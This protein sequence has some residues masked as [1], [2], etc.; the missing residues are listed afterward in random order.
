MQQGEQQG[1]TDS[2]DN[3]SRSVH[4]IWHRLTQLFFGLA[5]F[6]VIIGSVSDSR[7]SAYLEQRSVATG[8]SIPSAVTDHI[9]Q[10]DLIGIP[11]IG[12]MTFEYCSNSP[13][14]GV[15]CV[16]PSGLDTSNAVLTTQVGVSDFTVHPNTSLSPNKIIITRTA[17][18]TVPGTVSYRFSTITNPDGSSPTVYVRIAFYSSTDG[19]GVPG[20]SGSVTFSIQN[21]LTVTVYVPPYLTMCSGVTVSVDCSSTNGSTVDLGELSKTSPTTGTTQFAVSTN[22]F[23][24][25]VTMIQGSTMTAGNRVIAPLPIRSF[26]QGGVSQ[27]GINLRSNTAPS[28]GQNVIGLGTGVVAAEYNTPNQ[29][30]FVDGDTLASSPL[31]TEWNR[32]TISYLVNVG[33]SQQAGRYATTMTVIATTT[34]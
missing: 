5:L 22:S 7:T 1:S 21:P 17:G 33:S 2:D 29:F 13:L 31:A 14:P 11:F 30:K 12:S 15:P 24:G 3:R 32:Y 34:F 19:T 18:A 23:N 8:S 26:S 6:T 27:F 16:A 25:Y 4:I 20:D 28:V 10:F 9:F